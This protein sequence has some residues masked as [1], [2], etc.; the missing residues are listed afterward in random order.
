MGVGAGFALGAKLCRPDSQVWLLYGDGSAGYSIAEFDT[1]VRHGIPV[2]AVIGNDASWAQ[3]ARDQVELLGDDVA[4]KLL[5]TDYHTVAEGFGGAGFLL[6]DEAE[7][8]STLQRAA[9]AS[10]AGKPVLV[11]ARIGK[12]EFRKG[13]ISI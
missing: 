3:I 2:I 4:C 10:T 1:F 12:T 11:N 8:G 9:E 5:P 13:S 6:E 7:T